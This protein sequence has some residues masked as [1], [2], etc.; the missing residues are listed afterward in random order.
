M[1]PNS[2]SRGASQAQA[3]R[4]RG[5]PGR[6]SSIWSSPFLV[7]CLALAPAN[8]HAQTTTPSPQL[9]LPQTGALDDQFAAVGDPAIARLV[10][11]REWAALASLCERRIAEKEIN[12]SVYYW[13]GVARY[14]LRDAIASVQALRTSEKLGN[15]SAALHRALGLAYYSLNQFLLFQAQ[16]ERASAKAPADYLPKYF[17]GLYYLSVRSDTATATNYFVQ[18]VSLNPQDWKSLYQLGVCYENAGKVDNAREA[19]TKAIQLQVPNASASAWPLQG[20][21][22]ILATTSPPE[23]IGYAERAVASD[24]SEASSHLVLAKLYEQTGKTAAALEQAK[25]AVSLSPQNASGRYLL[26][27][28]YKKVGKSSEAE[29]ELKSFQQLSSVYGPE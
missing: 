8:V 17:V 29:A 22:R 9:E 12:E 15:D 1:T 11:A 14:Q 6:V 4:R 13:L 3:R 5:L 24:P 25:I 16:M 19:Y 7:A 27:R 23:A 10:A 28:L 18:A 2:H 26:F 21:A 20:M